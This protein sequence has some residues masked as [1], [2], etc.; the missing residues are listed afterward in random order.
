[1][2]APYLPSWSMHDT[3]SSASRTVKPSASI[4]RSITRF[5]AESSTTSTTGLSRSSFSTGVS[6]VITVSL[7]RL[8]R[9]ISRSARFTASAMVTCRAITQPMLT[10]GCCPLSLPGTVAERSRCCSLPSTSPKA[11]CVTPGISSKYSSP[12]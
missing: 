3:P 12:P 2:S 5:M 6:S 4:S 7:V 10:V 11:S 8:A 9:Y 1:M